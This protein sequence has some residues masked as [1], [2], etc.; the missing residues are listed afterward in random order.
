MTKEEFI[1]NYGGGS[2]LT[3]EQV[4]TAVHEQLVKL[5]EQ[6]DELQRREEAVAAMFNTDPRASIFIS[7]WR[8]G[9]DPVVEL[10]RQF[11][12]ELRES[13]DD[14][15]LQQKLAEANSEYLERVGRDK[16]LSEEF[17]KNI[18]AS[19]DAL[20]A[21]CERENISDEQLETAWEWLR[22][23]TD[24]G[25]RGIVTEEAIDM[26]LKAINH[27]KDVADADRDGEMRG[28]NTAI[29]EHLKERTA[30]DGTAARGSGAGKARRRPDRP[31]MG[32][33]D[34]ME[35]FRSVWD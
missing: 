23:V 2:D 11:G 14:P 21:K 20:D 33:I 16:A 24:K 29:E 34:H 1:S 26:A 25:L 10:V 32:I 5:R 18:A 35:T 3:D 30:S 15:A 17:G 27:D 31:P 7:N 28:R 6:L 8:A 13:L 19:L 12:P 4:F 9:S 22:D